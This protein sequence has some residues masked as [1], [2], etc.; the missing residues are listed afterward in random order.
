MDHFF[1]PDEKF[2]RNRMLA[3]IKTM[4][5]CISF[6]RSKMG[7]TIMKENKFEKVRLERMIKKIHR[8][9]LFEHVD[10]NKNKILFKGKLRDYHNIK[11]CFVA[12]KITN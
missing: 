1:V 12:K 4:K 6:S 8:E 10:V 2:Q 3:M 9:M 5:S 7:E 11:T